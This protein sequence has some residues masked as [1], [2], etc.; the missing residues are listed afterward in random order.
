V[1]DAEIDPTPQPWLLRIPAV[2]A[3]MTGEILG[4]LG[5]T[6]AKRLGSDYH[7]VK[8]KRPAALAH[9]DAAKF[10]R[11]NVPLH[12][13]WPCS[14]GEVERFIEKAATALASKFAAAGVQAV[15][16]GAIDPGSPNRQFRTLASN[17]RG[18]TL[19]L[20]AP[21]VAACGV[22]DQDAQRPSLFALL[23]RE[24]LFAGVQTPRASNGFFPGGTKFISQS[25]EATISRA[26]AKIAEALHFLPLRR[27]LPTAGAEWLELGASPGGMTSELLQRGFRVTAVDRAPL[28]A[29]LD[30]RPGLTFV[31][32]DAGHF[33]PAAGARFAAILCDLNSAAEQS[34][35]H[36]L[37]LT[38]S[39]A[40]G[41]LVVFTLK[42]A[43]VESFAA[44][45]RLFAAVTGR[46][47]AAGLRLLATTH[48]TYNRKEFTL[49][50]ER[51]G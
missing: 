29:R 34:I 10:I 15:M 16:L 4:E 14:P 21:E 20:F 6:A 43:G 49:F 31:R 24:G 17:L 3:G 12:H 35:G 47:A 5:A 51:Q 46:A 33:S 28:D 50:F 7:L 37:R 13:S 8:L 32:G 22:G 39:L 42:F 36:V 2:F 19:Q 23:G 27:A 41:G 11:W 40:P 9:S 44:I 26:G 25:A 48:L 18:R 38:E 30:G 1:P 45:N